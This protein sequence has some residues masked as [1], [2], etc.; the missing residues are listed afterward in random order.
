MGNRKSTI[1]ETDRLGLDKFIQCCSETYFYDLRTQRDNEDITDNGEQ[2][3]VA[4]EVAKLG[5]GYGSE[6]ANFNKIDTVIKEYSLPHGRAD[7]V[8]FHIDGTISVI[9]AKDGMKG[10]SHVVKGIGQVSL[11]ASQLANKKINI[12]SVSRYLLWSSVE[13]EATNAAITEAC[14]FAGV[15]PMQ[16][17]PVRESVARGAC[18]IKNGSGFVKEL[19]SAREEYIKQYM[20]FTRELESILGKQ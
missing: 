3:L 14:L 15:I 12:K 19:I 18:I 17:E 8:I 20:E 6:I 2:T 4:L 13:D 16:R 7:V 10:Y 1:I 11:Y 5:Y 9:E